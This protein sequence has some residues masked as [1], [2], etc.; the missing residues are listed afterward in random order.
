MIRRRLM[1]GMYVLVGHTPVACIDLATWGRWH[2]DTAGRTVGKTEVGDA[3]VSTVCLG[4]D[5]GGGRGPPILFE[6][7]IF[8][9]PN[10]GKQERCATWD[11]AE[12]MHARWVALLRDRTGQV[13]PLPRPAGQGEA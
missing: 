1:G 7:M 11:Q 8:G 13:T 4:L 12:A 10:D 3:T 9:G 5:H 6:T 2:A